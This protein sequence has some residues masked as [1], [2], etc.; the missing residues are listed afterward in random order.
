MQNL[1]Q[2]V[3]ARAFPRNQTVRPN[4]SVHWP[5]A[6]TARYLEIDHACVEQTTHSTRPLPFLCLIGLPLESI[7]IKQTC[8]TDTFPNVSE[9]QH[10]KTTERD[11]LLGIATVFIKLIPR[12][13]SLEIARHRGHA[14]GPQ[15]ALDALIVFGEVGRKAAL[16]TLLLN[17]NQLLVSGL[18]DL[19][20]LVLGLGLAPD[21]E[22]GHRIRLVHGA[23]AGVVPP[24]IALPVRVVR[25]IARRDGHGVGV[26]QRGQAA[27][28]G[29]TIVRV[30]RD[31][32]R[33]VGGDGEDTADTVPEAGGF[34]GV[35]L[36]GS[37]I[38]TIPSR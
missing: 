32:G 36:A 6:R 5:L 13:R 17:R 25:D 18:P 21:G 8:G 37:V 1:I 24:D 27:G 29:E 30:Q 22:K 35:F 26:G 9:T 33:A 16:F 15:N 23:Q 4:S 12:L 2:G 28:G 10:T 31:T 7:P 14:V 34:E 19:Q 11:L 38:F 3:L 20:N